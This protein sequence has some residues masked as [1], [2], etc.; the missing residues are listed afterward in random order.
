MRY[1]FTN[2]EVGFWL[3]RLRIF[4][5]YAPQ[6]E[7][8]CNQQTNMLEWVFSNTYS[9]FYSSLL[10]NLSWSDNGIQIFFQEFLNI[11]CWVMLLFHIYFCVSLMALSHHLENTRHIKHYITVPESVYTDIMI[12]HR[13]SFGMC[14]STA[15]SFKLLNSCYSHKG[16]KP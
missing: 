16:F 4:R 14:T 11:L 1:H 3:S 10:L 9:Y 6:M 8:H 13:W 15:K 5:L 12:S 2:M 7:L